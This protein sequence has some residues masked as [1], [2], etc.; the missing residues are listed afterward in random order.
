MSYFVYKV[1]PLK[2]LEFVQQTQQYGEARDLARSMRE[3]LQQDDDYSVKVIFA[4]NPDEAER[5]LS[6][7]REPRPVGEE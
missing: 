3:A 5:L 7:E 4:Q 2:R 6:E 1:F